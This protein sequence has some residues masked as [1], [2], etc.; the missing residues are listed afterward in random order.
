MTQL[1]M[2][3]VHEAINRLLALQGQIRNE[4]ALEALIHYFE[5]RWPYLPNYNVRSRAGL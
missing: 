1:W 4:N 3:K 5:N 2:G